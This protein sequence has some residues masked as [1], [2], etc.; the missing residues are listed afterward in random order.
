LVKEFS[1]VCATQSELQG[2]LNRFNETIKSNTRRI[3]GLALESHTETVRLTD[4]RWW[5]HAP[6]I[7]GLDLF[8]LYLL[9]KKQGYLHYDVLQAEYTRTTHYTEKNDIDTHFINEIYFNFDLAKVMVSLEP[10]KTDEALMEFKVH[11]EQFQD[12]LKNTLYNHEVIVTYWIEEK[13]WY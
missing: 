10:H 2:H 13:E 11:I 3:V 1:R 6:K 9:W 12:I 8:G 4:S 7:D 5:L